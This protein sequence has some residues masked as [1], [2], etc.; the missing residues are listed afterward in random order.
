MGKTK[1]RKV[2]KS[3]IL[4]LILIIL[5]IIGVY[6]FIFKGD[7]KQT[8][9][10]I[11]VVDT[12]DDFGYELNDNETEYYNE[13]FNSLKD[14]LKNE[15]Y[16]EKEYASLIGKLFLADFYDLNSKIMKSDVGGTQFV[17]ESYR[18]DFESGAIDGVYKSIESNVYGDRKQDLPIITK[19]DVSNI[20]TNV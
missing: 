11:E 20:T 5:F 16:D 10:E 4:L 2:K 1:K 18:N 9:T 3:K 12:I 17:Y 15:G 13:L 8:A 7:K 19:V 14:L 6:I